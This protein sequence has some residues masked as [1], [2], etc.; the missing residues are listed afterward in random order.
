VRPD[1]GVPVGEHLAEGAVG[2]GIVV[3]LVAGSADRGFGGSE[4]RLR[5]LHR[6]HCDAANFKKRGVPKEA[7]RALA[8][9]C[10]VKG[11][12]LMTLARERQV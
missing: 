3:L 6:R 5:L 8:L 4:D 2:G 9:R 7:R 12:Q 1:L 11:V 10:T